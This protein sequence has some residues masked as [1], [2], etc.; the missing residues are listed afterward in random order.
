MAVLPGSRNQLTD[1][2][3]IVDPVTGVTTQPPYLDIRPRVTTTAVDDRLVIPDDSNSEW[4]NLGFT[5]L[6][7]AKAWWAIADLSNVV[8]PF[9]DIA[10]AVS[11]SLMLRSPSVTRYL[12]NIAVPQS[13]SS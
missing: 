11:N 3:T 1:V 7:D 6:D 2:I 10:T 8:D 4:S 12:F 5:V 13:T 9:D